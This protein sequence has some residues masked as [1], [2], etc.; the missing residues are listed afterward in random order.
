MRAT[1]SA[2]LSGYS[3]CAVLWQARA[4][5]WQERVVLWQERAI[6]WQERIILWQER[7]VLW[8]ERERRWNHI[9]KGEK[10]V[11]NRLAARHTRGAA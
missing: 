9:H 5:L 2:T 8:Q 3:P 7:A 1:V 6:L 4:I 11:R 10:N